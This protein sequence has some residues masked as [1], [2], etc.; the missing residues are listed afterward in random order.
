MNKMGNRRSNASA[1][2]K[3]PAL[4]YSQP[5]SRAL[6]W[7]SFEFNFSNTD[8]LCN[9]VYQAR[10]IFNFTINPS[11]YGSCRFSEEKFN[12]IDKTGSLKVT[13]KKFTVFL[14]SRLL[15]RSLRAAQETPVC[16]LMKATISWQNYLNEIYGTNRSFSFL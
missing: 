9:I 3:T 10:R 8:H 12:Y 2:H 11:K 7:Q 14:K 13:Q 5:F 15:S 1:I 16:K 6:R 4:L